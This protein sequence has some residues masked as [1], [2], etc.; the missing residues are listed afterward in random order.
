MLTTHTI[1]DEMRMTLFSFSENES[2]LYHIEPDQPADDG[3][4]HIELTEVVL[5]LCSVSE[6]FIHQDGQVFGPYCNQSDMA[7]T[8]HRRA[9]DDFNIHL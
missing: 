6:M 8:R 4:Y 7:E 1:K 2:C 9:G 3:D 5:P